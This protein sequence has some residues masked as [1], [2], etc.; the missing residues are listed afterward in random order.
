MAPNGQSVPVPL[1]LSRQIYAL[2]NE[3]RFAKKI[4]NFINQL[5]QIQVF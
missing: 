4:P 3:W 5:K 2:G 1:E